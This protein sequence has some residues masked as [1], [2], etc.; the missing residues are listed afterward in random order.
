[1]TS[2]HY[3]VAYPHPSVTPLDR[4]CICEVG[5]K[6]HS[7]DLVGQLLEAYPDYVEDLKRA[8]FWKV[9]DLIVII[10]VPTPN[11]NFRLAMISPKQMRAMTP[12]RKF[13]TGSAVGTMEPR[14]ARP[15]T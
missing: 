3:I 12:R 6:T 2:T 5:P 7:G 13:T 14:F 10:A 8:R 9:S 1:M 4:C 15:V 11:C